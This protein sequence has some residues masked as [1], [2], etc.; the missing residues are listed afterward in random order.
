MRT[1]GV[2]TTSR[3][4]FGIYRPVLRRIQTDASLRLR[5]LVTGM[6]LSPEF[7]LTVRSIV[8]DGFT[9]DEK[10]ETLLSSDSPEGVA[11]AI[12][13]GVLGFAQSY[14]RERPDLL[15]VLGDRF[16][17]FAAATAAIPFNL[18]I[19]HLHGGESTEGVIDE[20]IRHSITKMSH[21]HFTS[22]AFYRDRVIN[23]GEEPWRVRNVGAPSLDN[24]K[25]FVPLSLTEIERRLAFPLPTPPLIV[26]FHPLTLD[27]EATDHDIAAVL[28]AL[29][30]FDRPTV[31]TYPNADTRGRVILEQ[32]EA[33]ARGRPNVLAVKDLGTEVYFSLMAGSAAMVGN[34]SSGIIE[35]ASFSLPVVNIGE[36]QLGRIR[37]K[38]V[39]DVPCESV[40]IV[41]AVRRALTQDFR[42]SLAD[43]ENPY[44]RGGA[45]E[46]IV[47]TIRDV[48]LD[49]RLLF[50]RFF[51]VRAGN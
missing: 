5:L 33:Y 35:A 8:A 31:I 41:E 17:M 3:A 45:S 28:R 21:L 39:I 46:A 42:A 44:G 51:D 24:L 15:L 40:A 23:M 11:K 30:H 13:L 14:S 49:R 34:S 4:D 48:A 26:T 50:K 36:R 27:S 1:I 12:G 18:P 25:G 47:E 19:A 6:H 37:G 7:G 22:T 32:I 43:L 2:V 20:A 29:S 38:N 9:A 10:I 16:E